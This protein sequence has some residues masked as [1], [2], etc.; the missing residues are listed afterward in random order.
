[1]TPL[2]TKPKAD[3]FHPSIDEITKNSIDPENSLLSIPNY[4]RIIALNST[5]F[6]DTVHQEVIDSIQN[7]F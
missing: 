4:I 1:M 6:G 5:Y 2:S 3:E 7:I